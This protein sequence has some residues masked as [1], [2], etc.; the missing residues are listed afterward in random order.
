MRHANGKAQDRL[1]VQQCVEHT[2]GA[3]FLLQPLRHAINAALARDIFAKHRD[4]GILQHDVRQ[5]KIDALGQG[6]W[7]G[8]VT[9]VMCEQGITF[10]RIGQG[11]RRLFGFCGCNRRHNLCRR[12]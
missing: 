11:L 4:I 9:R 6:R 7:L 1:F 5:G 2:H 3:E 8:K 12:Q 10:R